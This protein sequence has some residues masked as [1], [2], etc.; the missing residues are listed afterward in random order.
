MRETGVT[1]KEILF[2][3]P[4]FYYY[5]RLR[6]P[7]HWGYL[8]S[9]EDTNDLIAASLRSVG[10]NVVSMN[11]DPQEYHDYF[12]R[13]EYRTRY[14]RYYKGNIHEK[15]LEHFIAQKL[16]TLSPGD[17]YID[18]ASQHSPVPE[19]YS[20]LYG[21]QTYAQDLAY[22]HGI[23][24]HKIGGDAASLPLPDG[25]ATK[26]ALHCSLEHFENESDIG[27]V[28]EARRVLSTGGKLVVVPL[29][30]SER[31]IIL[32]DPLLYGL[33]RPPVRFEPEALVCAIMAYG[34][35]HGRLYDVEH[36]SKRLLENAEGLAIEIVR[37]PNHKE[38][39]SS[40]YASFALVATKVDS[41][42]T[43]G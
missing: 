11:L 9:R 33:T 13:A 18:I 2:G 41:A 38:I 20:R 42:V 28:R 8:R 25:F 3:A 7:K 17:I 37:F 32:T 4:Y 26:M 36:L 1:L 27:F 6:N 5:R 31:Y 34:N 43:G 22:A 19:I 29:Y 35:R 10:V 23:H 21:C 24:G 14:P 40:C 16:L 12:E 15:S 39:H 30:L